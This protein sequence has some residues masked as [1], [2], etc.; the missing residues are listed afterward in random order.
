AT[1]AGCSGVRD[2]IAALRDRTTALLARLSPG[3]SIAPP[4][5]GLRRLAATE[6]STRRRRIH[7]AAWAASLVAAVSLGWSAA[8]VMDPALRRGDHAE[9]PG[10]I[11]SQSPPTTAGSMPA[12]PARVRVSELSPPVQAEPGQVP[13]SGDRFGARKAAPRAHARPA[14]SELIPP[15]AVEP[16]T[17]E[18]SSLDP[19]RISTAPELDGVWRT[20]SWDGAQEAAGNDLPRIGGL[21]VVEVQ[22][23]TASEGTRPLM[24]V[25]Q[26]LRSGQVIRTIEGPATDVSHLLAR[27]PMTDPDPASPL[28]GRGNTLPGAGLPDHMM[29]MQRG[30]RMLAITGALPSDSLRAMIRRLNAEFR[31]H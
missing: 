4:F 16:A 21:P 13:L 31:T 29:A 25:A 11:V 5:D 22:V 28:P 19:L 3:P 10:P 14:A 18:L 15:P 7:R 2:D 23:Q 30:D 20:L 1:C 6:A 24:V 12:I 17:L 8:F 9:A 27:R 26:Q